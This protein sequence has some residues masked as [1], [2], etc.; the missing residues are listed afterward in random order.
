MFFGFER[1]SIS[2]GGKT[3]LQ[4]VCMDFKEGAIT[5][6]LGLNGTGKTSL[7]KTISRTIKPQSGAVILQDKDIRLYAKP[8][9]AKMVAYLSQVHTCPSDIPV[10]TLVSY[11]RFPHRTPGHGLSAE[12]NRIIDDALVQVGLS[13]LQNREMGKL[14]GGEVQRAWIAMAIA[15]EPK[16]LVLDE[17]TTHLDAAYQLETLEIL[18][19]LNQERNL[20]IVMVMH[21]LNLASRYSDDLYV[22]GDQSVLA[23]GTPEQVITEKNLRDL[24]HVEATVMQDKN[25]KKPFY[26]PKARSLT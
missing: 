10:R 26:I 12:D 19:R 3:I 23:H 8:Q 24:F 22:I 18:H 21:D 16:I 25:P 5:S 7:L 20:T 9:V 11:G 6:I 13:D 14:S 2:L 17:P 15:Q 4:N 1:I